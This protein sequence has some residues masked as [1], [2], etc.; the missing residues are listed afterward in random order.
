[1]WDKTIHRDEFRLRILMTD[2]CNKN[3][4]FCLNDFQAKPE[5]KPTFVDASIAKNAIIAYCELMEEVGMQ[6]VITFSGGEPGIHPNVYEIVEYAKRSGAFVK[7]V[8]NGTALY[9]TPLK[10][11]VDCW[12]VSVT[13]KNEG[14]MEFLETN[15]GYNVQIQHVLVHDSKR[16]I[17]LRGPYELVEFYGSR[18]LPIKLWVNFFDSE[19]EKKH[20]RGI[21]EGLAGLFP[22][23][24]IKSRF[25]GKQENRGEA[26]KG[27][28]LEC[29][30][31]KALWVFPDGSASTCPQG[32]LEKVFV[33]CWT[34]SGLDSMNGLAWSVLMGNAFKD[35]Q[36]ERKE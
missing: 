31:L 29:V 11:F 7:L 2:G 35:H 21:I 14:L 10:D 15:P 33:N 3:C 24:E 19:E 17:I 8:T 12:H 9:L 18:G 20:S 23:Y 26:C 36:F 5:D 25:T 27:C 16:R 34:D 6:P 28:K 22:D 32:V 4:S 1:M 13:K 30:T